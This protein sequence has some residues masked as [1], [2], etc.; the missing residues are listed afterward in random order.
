[1]NGTP[2]MSPRIFAR[3][4]SRS[5]NARAEK[6]N[7]CRDNY[8]KSKNCQKVTGRSANFRSGKRETSF[9]TALD[10]L[11]ERSAPTRANP[12]GAPARAFCF[13][14]FSRVDQGSTVVDPDRGS[15]PRNQWLSSG[16][17]TIVRTVKFIS[18]ARSRSKRTLPFVDSRSPFTPRVP[19]ALPFA[20]AV[21]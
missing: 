1:M 7:A 16:D 13:S 3:N 10:R 14:P 8:R 11:S 12:R 6:K 5:A 20:S 18:D 15:H 21:L 2:G 9:A 4:I 19:L 17:G